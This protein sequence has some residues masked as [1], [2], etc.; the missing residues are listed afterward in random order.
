MCSLN[1]VF[2]LYTH[3]NGHSL[4]SCIFFIHTYV[5]TIHNLCIHFS[6]PLIWPDSEHNHRNWRSVIYFRDSS[7]TV[8]IMSVSSLPFNNNLARSL[9]TAA[10]N[11]PTSIQSPAIILVSPSITT[12]ALIPVTLA[13]T[14]VTP[15]ITVP[16]ITPVTP[17]ITS[18]VTNQSPTEVN[19]SAT[20]WWVKLFIDNTVG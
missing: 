8:L 10:T 20:M 7:S 3:A 19:A 17:P 2:V 5:H 1:S 9:A 12:P 11:Q 13:V 16:A 6:E 4:D 18:A 14:P 15:A